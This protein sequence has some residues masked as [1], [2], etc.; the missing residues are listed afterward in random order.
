[1]QELLGKP[2][3]ALKLSDVQEEAA[4]CEAILQHTWEQRIGLQPLRIHQDIGKSSTWSLDVTLA[5]SI[6]ACP[7]CSPGLNI[8]DS[9]IADAI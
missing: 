7:P 9:V 5:P 2:D 6:S 3:Q 8:L 1:M 4:E